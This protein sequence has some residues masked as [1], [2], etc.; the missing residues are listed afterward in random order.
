MALTH[1]LTPI[2]IGSVEVKNR[3]VRTAHST[4]IGGGTLSDDLVAYHEARAKGGVGL[5]VM[6]AMSVHPSS[7]ST[8]NIIDPSLAEKYPR[9]IERLRPHGMRVFQQLFHAGH[10]GRDRKSVV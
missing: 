5:T 4:A 9:M 10:H 1:V 7:L 8:L 6:E 3:V 2:R